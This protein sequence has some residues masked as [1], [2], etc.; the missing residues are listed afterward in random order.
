MQ[1]FLDGQTPARVPYYNIDMK[2]GH[3]S[4]SPVRNR[5]TNSDFDPTARGLVYRLSYSLF[6]EGLGSALSGRW[7]CS[8]CFGWLS[9]GVLND[10]WEHT[11][12]ACLSPPLLCADRA[13]RR[14][15]FTL[16]QARKERRASAQKLRRSSRRA[17]AR[18][19]VCGLCR[20]DSAVGTVSV[21]S[22]GVP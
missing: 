13:R 17:A 3:F 1:D 20:S 4:P 11:I 16:A 9:C 6:G 15:T 21:C 19:V 10:A 8:V 22:E 12:N 5:A 14:P 18:V 7:P 2:Y